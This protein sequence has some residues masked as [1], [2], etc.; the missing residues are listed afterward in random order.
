D[1]LA[2]ASA[3]LAQ[4]QV[5]AARR[6]LDDLVKK[7]PRRADAWFGLG[8]L[9]TQLG[10][11]KPAAQ[12][13]KRAIQLAPQVVDGYVHLGNAYLRQGRVAQAIETYRD[14]L[15]QQQHPLLHFNLGVAL[16]QSGDIPGAI[17]SYKTAIEQHPAYA[18]AYFSL[19]NAYRD[20]D[21]TNEAEAAYRQA[22]A[23]EP[24]FADAH[25][26]LAGLLATR[27]D[28][29]GAIDSCLKAV[30][31]APNHPHALRNMS[32]SLYKIG[33]YEQGAEVTFRAIAVAPDDTM[34][35]YHMGEMLYGM[36]RAGQTDKAQRYARQWRETCKADP[37]AQHMAAAIL[38]ENAP[39]RADDTYVRETFDRFAGDFEKTLAGLGYRVPEL[40]C[41]ALQQQLGA[42]HGLAILDAGCGTGL[43]APLLK[44]LAKRL[45]GVDLSGGM[46]AKAKARGL[47]DALHEAELGAFLGSAA[48]RY[49]MT[50]AADVFCY[51]GLLDPTL[52]AIAAKT[53]PG[54]LLGFTVEAMQGPAPAEGFKLG[55][56]GRYQHDEGYLRRALQQ[57][58]FT[59]LSLE[60][61]YGREEMGQPVPCFMV[62]ARRA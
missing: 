32:L 9:H 3:L 45:V 24:G 35:Q 47:Y 57:A 54:G 56:T 59:V 43:C 34:L 29:H 15:K 44:P 2:M 41:G 21:Q 4:G 25:A 28:F 62:I 31:L 42:R 40:L 36:I 27:Q 18:Q 39:A 14:G 60:Q 52:Q 23:L 17:A 22:V 55:P 50:V 53:T 46:L 10:E 48:E 6:L 30:A 16:R 58:G 7:S 33:E 5:D 8:Q 49:D 61:T 11:A 38:G 26:N 12:A 19:G 51:F 37:V 13:F 20:A 1:P